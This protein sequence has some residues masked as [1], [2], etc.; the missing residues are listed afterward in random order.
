[1]EV[2]PLALMRFNG[3]NLLLKASPRPRVGSK[4]AISKSGLGLIDMASRAFVALTEHLVSSR[5]IARI[6]EE[7]PTVE[8]RLHLQMVPRNFREEV[9]GW[10]K[11]EIPESSGRRSEIAAQIRLYTVFVV[12]RW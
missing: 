9:H 4:T 11:D 2:I 3:E 7:V 5:T 1:M 8:P 12:T 6:S 10:C